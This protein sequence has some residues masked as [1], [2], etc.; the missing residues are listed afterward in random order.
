MTHDTNALAAS[1]TARCLLERRV[2]R[3]GRLAPPDHDVYHPGLWIL[4]RASNT[5][6]TSSQTLLARHD[7]VSGAFRYD[8]KRSSPLGT[9]DCVENPDSGCTCPPTC[10]L[11]AWYVLMRLAPHTA[12]LEAP[13][14]EE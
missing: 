7:G 10:G 9:M 13:L 2:G 1:Q 6:P 14:H 11:P 3:T 8:A 5:L 4:F 12:W